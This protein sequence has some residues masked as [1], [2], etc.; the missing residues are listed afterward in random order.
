M[1]VLAVRAGVPTQTVLHSG[2]LMDVVV[3]RAG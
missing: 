1:D 3:I 2:A